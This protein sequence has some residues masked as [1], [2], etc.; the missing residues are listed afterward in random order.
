MKKY[1]V[2][3]GSSCYPSGG[4]SDYQG[5]HYSLDACW[6]TIACLSCDWWQIVNGETCV[7]IHQGKR[8]L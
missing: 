5:S 8:T 3:A 4:W 2:F 7:V 6:R 1:H